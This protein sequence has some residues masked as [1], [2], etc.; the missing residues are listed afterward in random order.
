MAYD[1]LGTRMKEFYENI[2]KTKL[3]RRTPVAARIDGKSFHTFTKG[4]QRPF[5]GVLISAM[6][7]T[8]HYLCK[9]I[10]GTVLGYSQSDEITLILIDYQTFTTEAYFDYEVQKLCSV[11][12][13]MATLAFNKYF[14]ECIDF[15][16]LHSQIDVSK[17]IEKYNKA[18]DKGAMFDC[19]VFNIPKEEVTNLI[20][21]R[22]LDARRNSIL[23]AG[24]TYY[25]A[26]DLEN[27]S[28]EEVICMLL[29]D[30]DIDWNKYP[31][32]CRHGSACIKKDDKWM[33]DLNMPML[34][35][36]DRNYVEKLI[37]I[38]EE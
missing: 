18:L 24:Q 14:K 27:H 7:K 37:Y 5:D 21:W 20:Y 1:E 30:H 22:Q 9:N 11:I 28:N 36:E 15:Y 13:S 3:M 29:K 23:M 17:Q 38:G 32:C 19:R 12:A 16:E 26:A 10:Q 8:M 34:K 35:G 6:Q 33:I 2:P 4:F 25:S 31:N